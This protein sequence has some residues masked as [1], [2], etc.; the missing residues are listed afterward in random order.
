MGTSAGLQEDGPAYILNF[1]LLQS[2]RSTSKD[3]HPRESGNPVFQRPWC[4]SREAAAYW[5][6]AC[7]GVRPKR[8]PVFLAMRMRPSFVLPRRDVHQFGPFEHGAGLVAV[9]IA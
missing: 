7:A 4:L 5:I 2:G 6:P 1:K 9:E 3:G 8:P